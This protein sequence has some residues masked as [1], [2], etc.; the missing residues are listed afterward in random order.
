MK[1]VHLT[2]R[3]LPDRGGV[4]THVSEVNKI[5]L[6]RGHAVSVFTEQTNSHEPLIEEI[7]AVSIKRLPMVAAEHKFPTWSWVWRQRQLLQTADII[8][9]HDIFW[10]LLPFYPLFRHKIHITFHGWETRY[11]VPWRFK[12]QRRLY[13]FLSQSSL[14]VGDWISEFYGDQPD[15]VTYGGVAL[16]ELNTKQ[17]TNHS[18]KILNVAFI[19]RLSA[20]NDLPKVITAFK[21]LTTL[22][23]IKVTFVGDGE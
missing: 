4:E 6:A 17:Q 1:I 20:D 11:P 5:L 10:W 8:Q 23:P 9:I 12:V 7:K 14:H 16:T 2:R 18:S 22:L 19:G 13:N 15:A 3:Y 21:K